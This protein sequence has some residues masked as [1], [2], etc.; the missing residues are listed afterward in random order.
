MAKGQTVSAGA[1]PGLLHRMLRPRRVPLDRAFVLGI[2]ARAGEQAMPEHALLGVL[3]FLHPPPGAATWYLTLLLLE[4]AAR[5]QG[6]GTT[7]HGAFAR[8]AVARGCRRLV[9]SVARNNPR[10]LRFWRDRIGYGENPGVA[11]YCFAKPDNRSLERSL[12]PA[13]VWCR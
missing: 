8:W 5:G 3:Y 9:V 10:A 11:A 12:D 1:A 7:V 4:P 6:L 2:Y 13:G